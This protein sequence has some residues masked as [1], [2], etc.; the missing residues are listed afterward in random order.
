MNTVK[1]HIRELYRKLDVT[2]RADAGARAE[3]LGLLDL[4]ESPG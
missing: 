4:T 1:T 3:P 2:S